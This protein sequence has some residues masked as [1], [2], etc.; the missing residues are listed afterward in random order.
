MPVRHFECSTGLA[1]G[2]V[3]AEV[4]R[5][6]SDRVNALVSIASDC[7]SL[8]QRLAYCTQI[9]YVRHTVESVSGRMDIDVNDESQDPLPLCR[10]D[11]PARMISEGAKV[12]EPDERAS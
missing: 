8:R 9:V 10:Q 2:V 6:G 12:A 3:I 7:W 4:G 1:N 5:R 11:L